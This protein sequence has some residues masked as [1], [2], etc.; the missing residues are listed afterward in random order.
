MRGKSGA[1]TRLTLDPAD[2]PKGET[3]WRRVDALTEE[4]LEQAARSDPDAQPLSDQEL[5]RFQRLPE[6]RRLRRRLGMTQE[7]FAETFHL[8]LGTVRDWEQGRSLPDG[9]SRVLLRVIER[10]PE[11]VL[12]ALKRREP[13]PAD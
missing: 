12:R 9:P 4:Q 3:D 2:P 8:A 1:T 10:E 6:V 7:A 13:L 11:A 5:A